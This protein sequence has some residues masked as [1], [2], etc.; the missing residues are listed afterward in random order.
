MLSLQP[1]WLSGSRLGCESHSSTFMAQLEMANSDIFPLEF[2][3]T[4]ISEAV[5]HTIQQVLY[6]RW[7]WMLEPG[8]LIRP[9]CVSRKKRSLTL[10]GLSNISSQYHPHSLKCK[11]FIPLNV[12]GSTERTNNAKGWEAL[13]SILHHFSQLGHYLFPSSYCTSARDPICIPGRSPVESRPCREEKMEWDKDE[14]V[15][16][17]RWR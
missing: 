3:F 16:R 17:A 7:S 14:G 12:T 6:G 10:L 15:M 13:G 9:T 2:K 5:F 8:F 4:P 1:R 11:P